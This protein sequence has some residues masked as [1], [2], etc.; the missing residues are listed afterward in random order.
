MESDCYN[1]VGALVLYYQMETRWSIRAKLI[2]VF[3]AMVNID[4]Q[5]LSILLNSIL[6]MELAREIR[7]SEG[8]VTRICQCAGLLVMLLC[9]GE[10][11]PMTAFDHLGKDFLEFV[12]ALVENPPEGDEKVTDVFMNLLFAYNLQFKNLDDNLIVL[13]LDE[14]L[15][16]NVFTQKVIYFLNREGKL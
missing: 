15:N 1:S 4:M 6:P 10:S 3:G 7:E 12:L 8:H 16:A 13:T 2:D 9:V 14:R 5:A 11:L